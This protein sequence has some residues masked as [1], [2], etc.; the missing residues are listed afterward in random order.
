MSLVGW[1]W[2]VMA[3]LCWQCSTVLSLQ[4]QISNQHSQVTKVKSGYHGLPICRH[5]VEFANNRT[6]KSHKYDAASPFRAFCVSRSMLK[7]ARFLTGSQCRTSGRI[8]CKLSYFHM[9][10]KKACNSILK[11]LESL[12]VTS[13]DHW[14]ALLEQHRNMDH[15]E[16]RTTW[17]ILLL[18][19]KL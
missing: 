5:I 4:C 2:L 12:Y 17:K 1:H 14:W 6:S 19:I 8:S 3:K 9:P 18:I 7:L 10:P 15:S 13:P 16:D 11:R